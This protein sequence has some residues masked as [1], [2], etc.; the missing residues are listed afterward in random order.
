LGLLIGSALTAAAVYLFD[1]F[2]SQIETS[3]TAFTMGIVS[4]AITFSMIIVLDVNRTFKERMQ[5]GQ[6]NLRWFVILPA[7]IAFGIV[8]L[9][10]YWLP[11]HIN[12]EYIEMTD[13]YDPATLDFVIF[14]ATYAVLVLAGLFL[15]FSIKNLR[16]KMRVH[17]VKFTAFAATN[18]ATVSLIAVVVVMFLLPAIGQTPTRFTDEYTYNDGPW[19]TWNGNP[20]TE[21]CISWLTSSRSETSLLIGNSTANITA[22][23]TGTGNAFLHKVFLSGLTPN[24]T[25][26][27]K[28]PV[29]F[30][31]AHA[32]TTFSF[33]TAPATQQA[34]K[35]TVSGDKQPS[36]TAGMLHFNAKVVDGI[37]AED[38]DFA[39]MLGDYASN[40]DYIS[41]WHYT[42]ESLARL[43]GT[44]PLGLAIGNHDEGSMNGQNFADMFTYDYENLSRGKYYAFNYSNAH[45]LVIDT[46]A[47]GGTYSAQQLA[48]IEADLVAANASTNWKFVFFHYTLMSTGGCNMDYSLQ[49]KLVPLFDKYQV[50]AVFYG[51]DHFYEHYNYTYGNENLVHDASHTWAHKPVQYFTTGG[52]GANLE[53]YSYGLLSRTESIVTRTWYNLT[54]G[55]TQA[56]TYAFKSWAKNEFYT[57]AGDASPDDK[58]YYQLP[59]NPS[60]PEIKHFGY[61]YGEN[62]YHYMLI[63]INGNTC[64]VSA[65]HV[66]GS[67][68]SGP[69]NAYPQQYVLTRS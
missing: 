21:A 58:V 51:H 52:G 55:S 13:I 3:P 65:R 23:R 6:V 8:T 9:I 36:N 15:Y 18:V 64:T 48:W 50:D 37:M 12:Y 66:D 24:T 54:L 17:K 2:E 30:S 25:Y 22:T 11:A 28:I 53:A 43:G 46:P 49:S 19:V 26:Y 32:S 62:S 41:D 42:L 5:R 56:I 34:F 38:P 60:Q 7:A 57:H 14:L 69:N 40:G 63:E 16:I 47:L 10:V 44:T 31:Q 29:D 67:L 59:A 20:A 35:F 27:Y 4:I 1:N 39:M 33:K 45:F 61:T 68:M